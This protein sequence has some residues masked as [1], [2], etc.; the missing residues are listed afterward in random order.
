MGRPRWARG[1]AADLR[2]L[3]DELLHSPPAAGRQLWAAGVGLPAPVEF[4]SGTPIAPPIM[5]GWDGFPVR[6]RVADNLGI[7][8]WVDNEVNLLALGELRAGAARGTDD[9]VYVKLGTGIGAGLISQGRLHRGSQAAPAMS[10]MCG[11]WTIPASRASA[12]SGDVW[13]RSPVEARS[14][15][16]PPPT[17]RKARGARTLPS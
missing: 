3:A 13:R 11:S 6:D 7:P 15:D 5:P 9:L 4:R 1:D 2:H 14:S 12:E 10:A 8:V 17:S 16:A